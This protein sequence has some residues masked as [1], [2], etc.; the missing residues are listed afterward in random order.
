MPIK[1]T[2]TVIT[3]QSGLLGEILD[4]QLAGVTRQAIPTSHFGTTGGM[5]YM[6]AA[7]YDPGIYTIQAHFDPT[8]NYQSV[9]LAA[10]EAF[11]VTWTDAAATDHVL[12]GFTIDMGVAAPFEDRVI[13]TWQ[14]R[15]TGG[16]TVT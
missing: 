3:F 9:M 15:I 14:V 10:A 7:L 1:G 5:T 13:V 6:P 2:G 12:S 16:L 11:T 8:D 4:M